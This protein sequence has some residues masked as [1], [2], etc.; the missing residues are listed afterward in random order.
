M[1]LEGATMRAD[2]VLFDLDWTLITFDDRKAIRKACKTAVAEAR[3]I[4]IGLRPHPNVYHR[5][6]RR[7]D[8]LCRK[9]SDHRLNTSGDVDWT[10]APIEAF[11]EEVSRISERFKRKGEFDR[12][13]WF[14]EAFGHRQIAEIASQ[15][16][17][18]IVE[19][20][21]QP[22]SKALDV[23]R[24]LGKM[25]VIVG[26]VTDWDGPGRRKLDRI[27][28]EILRLVPKRRIF[29]CREDPRLPW[30]KMKPRVYSDVCSCLQVEARRTIMI[31]D[32][33]EAD[34]A[35]AR[36]AGLIAKLK[37]KNNR[38]ET[39]DE[40]TPV[41][42]SFRELLDSPKEL[43]REEERD[44]QRG[45]ERY[46]Q[47][48]QLFRSKL[49]QL[50]TLSG[51]LLT[52]YSLSNQQGVTNWLVPTAGLFISCLYLAS[53]MI[54]LRYHYRYKNWLL[55][56]FAALSNPQQLYYAYLCEARPTLRGVGRRAWL[57]GLP[58]GFSGFYFELCVPV[59]LAIAWMVLLG[60]QC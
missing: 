59:L 20:T 44:C 38:L 45:Q 6:R 36:K 47:T 35:P 25:R 26:I 8:R 3:S 14:E 31:G 54:T 33:F 18:E 24:A 52:A 43:T 16:Y 21:T 41:L 12:T 40:A 56:T 2:A 15:K 29:V 5:V 48:L 34:I 28:R 22:D 42:G 23:I 37:Q 46:A 1:R 57:R 11:A 60:W 7:W 49:A 55:R 30:P 19:E 17:W 32:K 58:R 39:R 10:R 9:E 13:L 50:G 4:G 27:P 53:M 51:L